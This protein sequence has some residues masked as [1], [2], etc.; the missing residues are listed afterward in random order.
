MRIRRYAE[1]GAASVREV[2]LDAVQVDEPVRR[3]HRVDNRDPGFDEVAIAVRFEPVEGRA[4]RSC[5]VETRCAH[6]NDLVCCLEDP[7]RRRLEHPSTR[8][9]TNEV[10]VALEQLDRSPKLRLADR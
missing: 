7:S 4:R 5:A 6:N 1:A 10:V 9:E 2:A 3:A 8:V